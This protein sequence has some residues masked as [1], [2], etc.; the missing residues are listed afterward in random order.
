MKATLGFVSE[1]SFQNFSVVYALRDSEP[2]PQLD[3]LTGWMTWKI[4]G[5]ILQ[6]IPAE[7][8]ALTLG[9]VMKEIA[10]EGCAQVV[11]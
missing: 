6:K 1:S 2:S 8:Y 10:P 3:L 5:N 9:K 4:L 11:F 7:N